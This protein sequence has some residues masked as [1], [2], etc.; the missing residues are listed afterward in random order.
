ML[1]FGTKGVLDARDTTF[2][3]KSLRFAAR[4]LQAAGTKALFQ[5]TPRK[6]SCPLFVEF[7]ES[8]QRLSV[9]CFVRRNYADSPNGPLGTSTLTRDINCRLV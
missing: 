8:Q 9:C 7:R 2:E 6:L 5:T 3:L 1:E 4:V